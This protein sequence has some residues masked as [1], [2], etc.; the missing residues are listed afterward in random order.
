MAENNRFVVLLPYFVLGLALYM[1]VFLFDFNGLYGQDSYEYLRYTQALVVFF[2]GGE[3]PLECHY[4]VGY[5]LLASLFAY[6]LPAIFVLQSISIVSFLGAIYI[7]KKI[8]ILL[9]GENTTHNRFLFLS[10]AFSPFFLRLGICTMSEMLCIFLFLNGLYF[11]IAWK[12]TNVWKDWLFFSISMSAA[13]CVRY[14]A[15]IVLIPI[16][17]YGLYELWKRKNRYLLLLSALIFGLFLLPNVYF[18]Q[19]YIQA[20]SSNFWLHAWNPLYIFQKDFPY[21]LD[22]HA[23]YHYPNIFFQLLFFVHPGYCLLGVFLLFFLKKEDFQ[24]EMRLIYAILAFYLIYLAGLPLQ[25]IRFQTFLYPLLIL[26]YLPAFARLIS[27]ITSYLSNYQQNQT[28]FM[29]FSTSFVLT[30]ALFLCY[31]GTNTMIQSNHTEKRMAEKLATF[32]PHIS[33]YALG[34]AGVIKCYSPQRQVISIFEKR[35]DFT[36]DTLVSCLIE[37]DFLQ[38]WKGKTCGNN[39]EEIRKE[40]QQIDSILFDNNWRIS[41][42][43]RKNY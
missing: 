27:K 13:F 6:F 14:V 22:G 31:K 43:K 33:I 26:I 5:P 24:G 39:F 10:L 28:L 16:A 11:F 37:K 34:L 41:V 29:S 21:S 40:Y 7:T 36:Q 42:W 30:L 38:Q 2:K 18:Y 23:L 3:F 35:I 12:K 20:S 1:G 8:A 15:A 25:N 19:S 9:Y 32:P 17:L 4:P